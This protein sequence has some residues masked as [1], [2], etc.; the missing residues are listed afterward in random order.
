MKMYGIR[1]KETIIATPASRA[2]PATFSTCPWNKAATGRKRGKA[3]GIPHARRPPL[4][5]LLQVR[6]KAPKK[7]IMS[8]VTGGMLSREQFRHFQGQME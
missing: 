7:D 5:F 8:T 6:I 3:G 2:K 4:Y 1:W